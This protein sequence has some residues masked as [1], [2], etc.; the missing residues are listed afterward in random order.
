MSDGTLFSRIKVS[1]KVLV[2]QVL[3]PMARITI[4]GMF[5]HQRNTVHSRCAGE[6]SIVHYNLLSVTLGKLFLYLCH[7]TLFVSPGIRLRAP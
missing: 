2:V 4:T 6:G 5:P 1:R 7:F 3:S